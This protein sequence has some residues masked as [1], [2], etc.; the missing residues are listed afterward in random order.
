MC[1]DSYA[2]ARKGFSYPTLERDSGL[3]S[4]LLAGTSAGSVYTDNLVQTI[5]NG[6]EA[7]QMCVAGKLGHSLE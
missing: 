6:H 7:Q 4:V 2:S 3:L 5:V 1:H